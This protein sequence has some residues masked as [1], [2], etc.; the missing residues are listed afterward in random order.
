VRLPRQVSWY[1]I[2]IED[3]VGSKIFCTVG[4]ERGHQDAQHPRQ[5]RLDGDAGGWMSTV[6]KRLVEL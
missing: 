6:L 2:A 4:V 3:T 5:G 1:N